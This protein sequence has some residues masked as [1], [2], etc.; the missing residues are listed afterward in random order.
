MSRSAIRQAWDVLGLMLDAHGFACVGV[1]EEGKHVI[2]A[3]GGAHITE[4]LACAD[5]EPEAL[6]CAIETVLT[7]DPPD[8]EV[9]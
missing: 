5:T 9:A 4:R 6:P 3:D 8:A 1:H 2:F 7:W